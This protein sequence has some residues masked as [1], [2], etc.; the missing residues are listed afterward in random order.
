VA[1]VVA[2]L[3][4]I[5]YRALVVGAGEFL[6]AVAFV[7][8]GAP[9]AAEVGY[10]LFAAFLALP[11]ALV[12]L[13]ELDRRRAAVAGGFN[14][15]TVLAFLAAFV[16]VVVGHFQAI[17]ADVV[18]NTR[19]VPE[20]MKRAIHQWNDLFV[21]GTGDALQV[22]GLFFFSIAA[23]FAVSSAVA[24]APHARMRTRFLAIGGATFLA[25][26]SQEGGR[27]YWSG[28]ALEHAAIL[29]SLSLPVFFALADGLA[30]AEG[31]PLGASLLGTSPEDTNPR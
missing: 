30:G 26:L 11:A 9:G 12:T 18:L 19:S 2:A 5:V 16:G 24:R 13:V 7:P 10:P 14:A 21:T 31:Q 27:L 29:T 22:L 8:I 6:L 4:R 1:P 20:G 15:V 3:R 25:A 28:R 17:Y 23:S